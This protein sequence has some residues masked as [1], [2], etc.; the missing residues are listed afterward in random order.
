MISDERSKESEGQ[1]VE[2]DED[3]Q[4]MVDAYDPETDPHGIELV[5]NDRPGYHRRRYSEYLTDL[6]QDLMKHHS[7]PSDSWRGLQGILEDFNTLVENPDYVYQKVDGVLNKL[8]IDK[9]MDLL[10][11]DERYIIPPRIVAFD[12]FFNHSVPRCTSAELSLLLEL[13]AEHLK[14]NH[15]DMLNTGF[16][17]RSFEQSAWLDGHL[18]NLYYTKVPVGTYGEL[19][20]P[21]R[22]KFPVGGSDRWGNLVYE[23]V[24]AKAPADE[25]DSDEIT[26]QISMTGSEYTETIGGFKWIGDRVVTSSGAEAITGVPYQEAP[27]M[28]GLGDIKPIND[29]KQNYL[30][31]KISVLKHLSKLLSDRDSTELWESCIEIIESEL[32]KDEIQYLLE[33]DIKYSKIPLMSPNTSI[34]LKTRPHHQGGLSDLLYVMAYVEQEIRFGTMDRTIGAWNPNS[35]AWRSI[36]LNSS[37]S[38]SYID[39]L[40]EEHIEELNLVLDT[41]NE[42]ERLKNLYWQLFDNRVRGL[43]SDTFQPEVT[44]SRA[45][46]SQSERLNVIKREGDQW[47]VIFRGTKLPPLKGTR[48][49]FT[50]F[51]V[52]LSGGRGVRAAEWLPRS[53][54]PPNLFRDNVEKGLMKF[55]GLANDLRVPDIDL[56]HV[57]SECH[58][59]LQS[60]VIETASRNPRYIGGLEWDYIGPEIPVS[61]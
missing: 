22:Q 30:N 37:S 56:S 11:G 10:S 59:H 55:E 34:L 44:I 18:G 54:N 45:A 16:R 9:G 15:K 6:T 23:Y 47:I 24:W 32:G 43:G 7:F 58:D 52:I 41:Y 12:D 26:L 21:E 50:L 8:G 35:K 33:L 27:L 4:E 38:R 3:F 48:A 46:T 36:E 5:Y 29:I 2:W 40:E 49:L 39:H 31:V 14:N 60:C 25:P 13:F 61:I 19:I 53:K 51:K 28:K 20:P 42:D 57:A 17:E 1:E